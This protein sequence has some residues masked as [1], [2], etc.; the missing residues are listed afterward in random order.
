MGSYVYE[1]HNMDALLPFIFHKITLRDRMPDISNWHRNI[2]LI[3]CYDGEGAV[4]CNGNP[5]HLL[6]GEVGVVNSE[7]IHV[8][9][10]QSRFSY[11][12]LIIDSGFCQANGLHI[13]QLQFQPI[14][15][16]SAL[17]ERFG[18]IEKAFAQYKEN[19]SLQDVLTIRCHVLEILRMLYTHYLAEETHVPDFVNQE[20]VKRVVSYIRQNLSEDFTLEKIAEHIGLSK[21][22]L[23]REFKRIT[24]TTIIE[25]I[26]LTR[27]TEAKR[28]I[29]EGMA[30]SAAAVACGYENTSYFTR[31]FKKYFGSLP[32]AIRTR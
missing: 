27:C 7:V 17:A 29:E 32:S 28:L 11:Y 8:C 4:N 2:E 10:P 24:G 14:I 26:N 30:V 31:V 6:P 20:H 16:D 9:V 13:E 23:S 12:C 22:H 21:F 5:L 25:F 18:Q 19:R 3:C 1:T 15:R